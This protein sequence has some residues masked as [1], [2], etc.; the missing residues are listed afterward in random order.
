MDLSVFSGETIAVAHRKCTVCKETKALSDFTRSK[1]QKTGYMCYCKDCNNER[2]KRYR[3]NEST[4]ERACKR[5]F[6]YAKRRASEKSIDFDIDATFLQSLY[7]QQGGLCKYTGDVLSLQAGCPQT[8][9]IDRIDSSSGYTKENVC[10]VTWEVNNAKQ[11]R[12]IEAFKILCQ[13]V[14]S[15]GAQ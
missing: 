1:H 9:S 6:S 13:K 8:V 3:K 2:N 10:L 7:L 15:H 4:L 5:I 11:A 12:S 14:V